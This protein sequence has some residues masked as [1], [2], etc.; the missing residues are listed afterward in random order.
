MK[1]KLSQEHLKFI[2][3]ITMLIDHFAAILLLELLPTTHSTVNLYYTLRIIGRFAFPIYCFLLVEGA[4]Y[5][6]S[7]QKYALRLAVGAVLSEL[8]YDLAFYGGWTWEHQSV[9]ITL[10]LGFASLEAMKRCP[11]LWQKLLAC[12]PFILAADLLH[13][14]YGADGVMLVILFALT[15]EMP[16]NRL[17]QGLGIWYVFSPGNAMMLNWLG[18]ISWTIQ[19]HAVLAILPISLYSGEKRST[20]KLQQ[21]AFYLFYPVHLT[22][23]YLLLKML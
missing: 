17:W 9:M 14:D 20:G 23:L 21:W 12:I 11:K 16:R 8:P 1:C 7:P 19:E 6:R 13:T 15:R 2:A 4:H 10:L 22:V 5:T 18:G 3:C